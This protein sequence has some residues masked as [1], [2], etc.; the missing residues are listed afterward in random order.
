VTAFII[1]CSSTLLLAIAVGIMCRPIIKGIG[2]YAKAH[3][4][5][6]AVAYCK[7]SCLILLAMGTT[8]K[9]TW[10][11]VTAAEA[12]NWQWWDWA[13]HFLAPLLSGLAVLGAFLDRSMQRADEVK[14]KT[15][16]HVPPDGSSTST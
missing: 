2:A 10:Q 16:N 6:Y 5:L 15:Q 7:A 13:I 12:G 3:A 8:F 9:E 14:A 11:P 4:E 1:L